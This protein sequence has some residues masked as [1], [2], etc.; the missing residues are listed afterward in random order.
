MNG[1]A[2]HGGVIPYAGTFF[3]FSDYMRPAVRLAALMGLRVIYV[4]THDSI[5]LGEDGPT[6][7]PIEQLASLRCMPNLSLIRPMDANEASAAW[8]MALQREEGPTGLLL[9][10]QKLPIYD[11]KK[12]GFASA[13]GALKGGYILSDEKNFDV[14]LI[15]SGSE[16]EIALDAK[17]VLNEQGVRVRIVSMPCTDVFDKQTKAYI[18]KVLPQASKR[19]VI[20]AG[21]TLTWHKYVGAQG[22]IIGL[23]HFG[24]SGPYDKVY[25]GFGLTPARV[26]SKVKSMLKR[27]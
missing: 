8:Q 11:R 21:A 14:V 16:V 17:K 1:M 27:G 19:L 24:A 18:E 3:V 22:E 12:E 9:T 6:H 23:D 20:E 4:W 25:K 5:G 2:L 10:R 15:S 7:Q 13:D 26:A